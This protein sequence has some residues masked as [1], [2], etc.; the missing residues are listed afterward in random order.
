MKGDPIAAVLVHVEDAQSGLRWYQKAFPEAATISVPDSD[1]KYLDV[2]GVQLEIVEADAKVNSGPA[3]SVVYWS[4]LDFDDRLAHLLGIGATL[5]RGPM[6]IAGGLRM[7][8]VKDPWG[9][10][11]GIRCLAM[12]HGHKKNS[13]QGEEPD[14]E[15]APQ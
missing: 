3:G 15:N 8:Q 4:T 2:Q 14:A 12:E 10:C 13:E 5:Y 1:F 6:E 9:N 11:L 7:C